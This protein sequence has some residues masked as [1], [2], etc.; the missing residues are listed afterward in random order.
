MDLIVNNIQYS[1][2]GPYTK[3]AVKERFIQR[4]MKMKRRSWKKLETVTGWWAVGNIS[5][6]VKNV[7]SGWIK[8]R[9]NLLLTYLHMMMRKSKIPR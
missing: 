6:H 2:E 5:I 8:L 4:M 9:E 3:L 1:K 7:A